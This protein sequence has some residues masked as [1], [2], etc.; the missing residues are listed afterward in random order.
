MLASLTYDEKVTLKERKAKTMAIFGNFGQRDIAGWRH[1]RVEMVNGPAALAAIE[2]AINALTGGSVKKTS[3]TVEVDSSDGV[4]TGNLGREVVFQFQ[5][6][7]GKILPFRL[8]GVLD[9][10]ILPGGEINTAHADV[11]A[12][13]SAIQANAVLSD[14]EV[15]TGLVRAYVVD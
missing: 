7:D 4:G 12:F 9:T 1:K 14:G 15:A 3:Y 8:R 13:A 2:G 11:A 10:Y 6:A 5:N